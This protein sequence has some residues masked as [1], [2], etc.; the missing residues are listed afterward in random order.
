M[1]TGSATGV[2]TNGEAEIPE[3]KDR[4]FR[5]RDVM[6]RQP[7]HNYHFLRRLYIHFFKYVPPHGTW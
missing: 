4:I 1:L 5:Y 7:P 6:L 2:L 3:E